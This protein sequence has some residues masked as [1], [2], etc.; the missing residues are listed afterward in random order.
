MI[1]LFVFLFF[2]VCVKLPFITPH[3][4]KNTITPEN[5]KKK[6]FG[7]LGPF[8]SPPKKT[9]NEDNEHDTLNPSTYP[10]TTTRFPLQPLNLLD[11]GR[12]DSD[13]DTAGV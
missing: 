2:F 4:K 10:A 9:L 7:A 13:R 5:L 11:I 1:R 8:L 3:Q 12:V 6:K